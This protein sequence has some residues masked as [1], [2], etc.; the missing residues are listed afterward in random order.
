[1]P[2][3]SSDPSYNLNGLNEN[4]AVAAV[5]GKLDTFVKADGVEQIPL[6]PLDAEKLLS[7]YFNQLPPFESK[8]PNEFK[9]AIVINAIKHCQS[10]LKKQ[11]C[12]VS[13][14]AG[15]RSAFA[16]DENYKTFPYLSEFLR[17]YSNSEAELKYL[18][19][20]LSE[21]VDDGE[22]NDTIEEY[23]WGFDI[24]R[25][26]YSEWNCNDSEI[27]GISYELLFIEKDKSEII[28]HIAASFN[29]SLDIT[30]R[31]DDTS[32][33]DKEENAY[34]I[35]HIIHANETHRKTVNVSIVCDIEEDGDGLTLT[36][37][38]LEEDARHQYI[39]LDDDTMIA[40]DEIENTLHEEPDLE[41]CHECNTLIGRTPDGAYTDYEGNPLCGNCAVSNENGEICPLCGRKYPHEYMIAGFCKYC[42]PKVD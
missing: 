29:I 22:F 14:D 9:D 10:T 40:S 3:L 25:G 16:D 35:E 23:L 15:F 7:D 20:F 21:R 1:M 41:Y 39:Y 18:S 4:Q 13:N 8:K 36:D 24:D 26:Q 11:V 33:F 37:F 31:D 32:Y 42:A 27:A 6:N 38:S 12:I 2:V 5:I 19:A 28:A 17:Y 30:Y 34:L